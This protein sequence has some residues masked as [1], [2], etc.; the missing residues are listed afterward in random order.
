MRSNNCLEQSIKAV[1]L[2]VPCVSLHGVFFHTAFSLAANFV[3]ETYLTN[4]D[5]N[6]RIT[7]RGLSVLINHP[8]FRL[9]FAYAPSRLI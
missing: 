5:T 4:S 6:L 1:I 3:D 9:Y 2:S 8:I 7:R